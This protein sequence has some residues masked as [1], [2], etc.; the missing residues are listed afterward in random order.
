MISRQNFELVT[1]GPIMAVFGTSFLGPWP[2]FPF[3][4]KEHIDLLS[5]YVLR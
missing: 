5:F 4:P 2:C 3:S 1:R